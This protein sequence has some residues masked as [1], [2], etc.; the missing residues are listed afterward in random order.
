MSSI[1]FPGLPRIREG[2]TISEIG[3]TIIPDIREKSGYMLDGLTIQNPKDNSSTVLLFP[4]RIRE[5]AKKANMN[6]ADYRKIVAI[7]EVSQVYFSRLIPTVL[8]PI[9]LT[10]LVE[11]APS[12]LTLHHLQEA[13]SD[14]CSM[15][16]AK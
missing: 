8:L 12:G 14:L 13:F 5:N 1:N 10:K 15:K 3:Q 7:N 6:E 11:R 4:D 16:F 2:Q 9:A